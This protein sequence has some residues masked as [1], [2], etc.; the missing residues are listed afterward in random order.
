MAETNQVKYRAR[1]S[2]E[3]ESGVY[4][5]AAQVHFTNNE[6]ILDM[7]YI[8]PSA[9]EPTLRVV[10]RINMSHKTAE[11]LLKALS[12]GILDWKNKSKESEK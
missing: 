9:A 2:E 8:L 11:S 3:M 12:N 5:N 6:C 10:S 7:A 1:I 4:S